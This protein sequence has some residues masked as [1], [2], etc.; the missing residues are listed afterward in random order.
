MVKLVFLTF[1]IKVYMNLWAGP[2]SQFI[3]FSLATE[4]LSTI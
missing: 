2:L 3:K 4:K 1:G